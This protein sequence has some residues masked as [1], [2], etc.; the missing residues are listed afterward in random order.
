VGLVEHALGAGSHFLMNAP[1][2][3][4]AL[5]AGGEIQRAER[6]AELAY[7]RAGGRLREAASLYALAE[8]MLA[9]GPTH[10]DAAARHYTHAIRLA[11]TVGARSTLA[12]A[13]VGQA[14]LVRRRGGDSAA[15]R[16]TLRRALADLE[17][18][19][20]IHH[21]RRARRLLAEP[22]TTGGPAATTM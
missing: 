20:F 11:E 2:V 22:L 3:V 17:R 16:D 1:L 5:L 19:G 10:W 18:L 21:A 4:E 14:D 8:V 12:Y 9:R 15:E 7:S 6:A 13:C